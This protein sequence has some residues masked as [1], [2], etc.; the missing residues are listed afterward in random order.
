MESCSL[1]I[2]ILLFYSATSVAELAISTLGLTHMFC[3]PWVGFICILQIAV[4]KLTLGKLYLLQVHY[5]HQ[6]WPLDADA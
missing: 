1:H 4:T 3:S 2:V 6:I 5:I